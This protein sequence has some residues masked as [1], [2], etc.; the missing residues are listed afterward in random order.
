[1]LESTWLAIGQRQVF[2]CLLQADKISYWLS[3]PMRLNN[4]HFSR[5]FELQVRPHNSEVG[6]LWLPSRRAESKRRS[7]LWTSHNAGKCELHRIDPDL[8]LE[9]VFVLS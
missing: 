7:A 1:M 5:Y 2:A 4:E 3:R 9:Q 6:D 8:A